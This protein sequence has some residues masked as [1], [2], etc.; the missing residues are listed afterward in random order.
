M[1]TY[2]RHDYQNDTHTRETLHVGRSVYIREETVQ[3]MSDVWEQQL[4]VTSIADSGALT[5]GS[6]SWY[7][8]NTNE[9][10]TYLIDATEEAFE[11]YR[12]HVESTEFD[13]GMRNAESQAN[14]PAIKDRVVK[15]VHGRNTP[16]GVVG[17]VVVVIERPYG[18]GYRS[19]MRPKLGIATSDRMI[20]KIMPNG[21]VFMNHA[22]MVWVWAHNCEVEKP[23]AVNVAE[24]RARAVDF[25]AMMLA[26]LRKEASY[27]N[28]K[29]AS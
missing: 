21:K 22:D 3:V 8:Q 25:A 5:S 4:V 16:K 12:A 1:F 20:E 6:I 27:Y 10:P 7:G 2:T 18:M 23:E 14:D 15:I 17:K 9:K 19:V 11:L 24:V 28:E 26:N 29:Y 13:K